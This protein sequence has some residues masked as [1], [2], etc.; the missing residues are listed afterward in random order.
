MKKIICIPVLVLM[1]G[2]SYTTVAQVKDDV[3]KGAKK[4]GNKTAEVASKTVLKVA[5]QKLKDK[6]GPNGQNIYVN[7][8]NEYYWIDKKGHKHYVKQTELRDKH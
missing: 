3:K 6:E 5:D 2:M 1:L 8:H 4:V 7:G